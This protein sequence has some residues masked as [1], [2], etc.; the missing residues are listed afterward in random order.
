MSI[1]PEFKNPGKTN[2]TDPRKLS[3]YDAYRLPEHSIL[4]TSGLNL[5][6]QLGIITGEK[7]FN[8]QKIL[9]NGI[10]AVQ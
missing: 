3:S 2:I 7:D 4:K 5:K 9:P 10:G 8:Q 1:V 6:Q